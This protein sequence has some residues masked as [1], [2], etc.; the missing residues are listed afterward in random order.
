MDGST[1]HV[2]LSIKILGVHDKMNIII[3]LLI[4]LLINFN[5]PAWSDGHQVQGCKIIIIHVVSDSN[6]L[7]WLPGLPAEDLEQAK[8]PCLVPL[9]T[10]LRLDSTGGVSVR[11]GL[12]LLF[13]P[14]SFIG[15]ETA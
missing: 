11:V 4:A 5:D 12:L 7:A 2:L 13:C 15:C 10:I 3:T 6:N 9:E 8:L 1:Y 14:L